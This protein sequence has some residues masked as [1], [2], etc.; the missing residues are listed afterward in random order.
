[1][2]EPR[3]VV[4]TQYPESIATRLLMC[5]SLALGA[6]LLKRFG[7]DLQKSRVT[8]SAADNGSG[9]LLQY[10][11]DKYGLG[12]VEGQSYAEGSHRMAGPLLQAL[13]RCDAVWGRPSLS[14]LPV[15]QQRRN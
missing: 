13:Q 3:N 14:V 5:F 4:N 12:V 9:S 10:Y 6:H 1:M 2:Q 15:T 11:S 7:A 8:L